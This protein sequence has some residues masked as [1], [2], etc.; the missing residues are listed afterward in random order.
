MRILVI[1]GA[2]YI[3]SHV[4]RAFLDKGHEV[5]VYDNLSSGCRENLFAD[6]RFVQGDIL[7]WTTLS[8]AMKQ[9]FDGL[10]HLA[11]FKAAGE[12]MVCESLL[13]EGV[14]VMFG[15]PGG[16]LLPFYNTLPE[17]PKIHHILCR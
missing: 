16:V 12:S 8:A 1:G 9:G 7:D 10:V 15:I 13:K 5:T 11:A 4:A 6:A 3:G 14:N 17:F 2:G